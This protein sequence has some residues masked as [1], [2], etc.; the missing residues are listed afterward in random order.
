VTPR[1]KH[2]RDYYQSLDKALDEPIG[3]AYREPLPETLCHYTTYDGLMGILGQRRI[4]AFEAATPK[5]PGELRHA[6]PAITKVSRAFAKD[7]R[8]PAREREWFEEQAKDWR[9]VDRKV[10]GEDA[11]FVACFTDTPSNE[12]LWE[13][14][15]SNHAGYAIEFELL[16]GEALNLPGLGLTWGKIAYD[17]DHAEVRLAAAFDG[18]MRNWRQRDNATEKAAFIARRALWIVC[19]YSAIFTKGR[20]FEHESE[21]RLAAV[22]RGTDSPVKAGLFRRYVEIQLREDPRNSPE[23]RAI[24]LGRTADAALIKELHAFLYPRVPLLRR[25]ELAVARSATGS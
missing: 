23:L 9:V 19:C 20:E 15:A 16:T 7:K 10:R 14:Y 12:Y 24:H 22:T 2:Q 5:D 6:D 13:H 4:R 3:I 21:W 11:V 1:Y 25:S 8:W 18:I 17:A